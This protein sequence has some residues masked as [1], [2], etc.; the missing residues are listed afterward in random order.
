[1]ANLALE[2]QNNAPRDTRMPQAASIPSSFSIAL[3]TVS[4]SRHPQ[5]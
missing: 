3:D 1:M 2:V 4:D 5:Q